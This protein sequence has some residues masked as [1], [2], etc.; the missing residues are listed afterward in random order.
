MLP[1][2]AKRKGVN[3]GLV[4]RSSFADVL[5]EALGWLTGPVFCALYGLLLTLWMPVLCASFCVHMYKHRDG[6]NTAS[7]RAHGNLSIEKGG[8]RTAVAVLSMRSTAASLG[9]GTDYIA[10]LLMAQLPFAGLGLLGTIS[11]SQIYQWLSL[12]HFRLTSMTLN[13]FIA[14]VLRL[15]IGE[16]FMHSRTCFMDDT[17]TTFVDEMRQQGQAAANVV[18]LGAGYDTRLYRLPCFAKN[19]TAPPPATATATTTSTATSAAGRGDVNAADADATPATPTLLHLYEV[20]A[21]GTQFE[22]RRVL[23]NAGIHTEHVTYASVD[24]AVESWLQVL[25]RNGFDASL[26]TCFIWEGITYYLTAE[27][28]LENLS[29]FQ[30]FSKDSVIGFDYFGPWCR[31]EGMVRAMQAVGEPWHFHVRADQ[32]LHQLLCETYHFDIK[33]HIGDAQCAARYVPCHLDGRPIGH[34]GDF[35]GFVAMSPLR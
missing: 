19:S 18:V 6:G 16:C 20:D 2:Q 1:S 27:V 14:K 4:A 23:L 22:K 17:M 12:V 29:I 32:H 24:F 21:P 26:P 7:S 34:S 11:L 25:K 30:Q 8:S 35:G 28:L 5:L 13:D 33:E 31:E 15:P 3:L 9:H 10:P